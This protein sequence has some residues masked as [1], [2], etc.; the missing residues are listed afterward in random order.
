MRFTEAVYKRKRNG[1]LVYDGV[2]C[3]YDEH[4]NES[5]NTANEK[6]RARP[7]THSKFSATRSKTVAQKP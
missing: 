1:K 7:E 6:H 5:S 3:Y 2:L 4:G